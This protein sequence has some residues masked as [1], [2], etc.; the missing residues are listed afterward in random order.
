MPKSHLGSQEGFTEEVTL[1]WG[2]KDYQWRKKQAF[3]AECI[4]REEHRAQKSITCPATLRSPPA[5]AKSS[6]EGMREA[7]G[8]IFFP[9]WPSSPAAHCTVL[10]AYTLQ[11][12]NKFLLNWDRV[13]E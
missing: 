11:E 5:A 2:F 12:F 8:T 3:Q 10:G 13:I 9:T 7:S 1:S 6:Q 4:M